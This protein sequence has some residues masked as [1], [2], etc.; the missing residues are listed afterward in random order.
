MQR[1]IRQLS[2]KTKT[3]FLGGVYRLLLQLLTCESFS[4]VS[5]ELNHQTAAQHIRKADGSCIDF[6]I[7]W[8]SMETGNQ[9]LA[10]IDFDCRLKK[11]PNKHSNLRFVWN[12]LHRDAISRSDA[13]SMEQRQSRLQG[14]WDC[15]TSQS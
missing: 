8:F 3:N 14:E 12:V 6:L 10:E 15:A 11:N 9:D 1:L 7:L 5:Q 13:S 4:C 2:G